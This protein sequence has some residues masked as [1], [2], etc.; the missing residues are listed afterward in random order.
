MKK[1]IIPF[2]LIFSSLTC[3][4]FLTIKNPHNPG[5]STHHLKAK[6]QAAILLDVSN[7]MDG[8][9]E[10]AKA[11]LWNM[12]NV[13]GKATCKGDGV[14]LEIALYEYGRT[15]NDSKEGFIKQL[16]GFSTDLDRISQQ[17]FSLGTDG[18]DE[19]CGQVIYKSLQ[20]LAWDS[21]P[22]NYKVIF[23]AGN[24][25]FLQGPALFGKACVEARRMGVHINSIYCG[26][27]QKGIR[28]HWNL[29]LE[30]GNGSYSNINANE[31][32]EDIP[33]PY[34]SVLFSLNDRLNGTYIAYG[35]QGSEAY[36]LQSKVDKMNYSMNKSVAAKRIEVKS[37]KEMYK[38]DSWD[39]V[40]AAEK[41]KMFAE[42]VDL[43]TLPDSLQKKTRAQLKQIIDT[44]ATERT[45]LHKQIET[46][47]AKRN[48]FIAEK[49]KS[50]IK[51]SSSL[52][53]EIEKIIRKQALDYN[54]ILP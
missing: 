42:K 16:S 41:D 38:N 27:K 2:L 31:K 3:F 9:I 54:I 7:S 28:E 6:I 23:I 53:S 24:E 52:G 43:K 50:S 17:L 21:N 5:P 25:D 46:V 44:K 22:G 18:G 35:S 51:Q 29:N 13:I 14:S 36:A 1:T 33:T 20:E 8:L 40:D 48:Q 11:Q 26:D 10:Q 19:Y 49:K 47:S 39:V 4:S 32:P 37:K 34:D 12:V 30:C 45:A 15:Q